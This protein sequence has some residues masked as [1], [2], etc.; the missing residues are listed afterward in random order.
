MLLGLTI[1]RG[2]Q[3]RFAA[4]QPPVP[5]ATWPFEQP[6]VL[7]TGGNTHA[8]L[9][10]ALIWPGGQ[11]DD[12]PATTDAAWLIASPKNAGP[13]NTLHDRFIVHPC[14]RSS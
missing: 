3:V 11:V 9:S 13:T 7:P 2:G 6:N 8:V 1:W 14:S 10:G 4:M 5:T 12:A